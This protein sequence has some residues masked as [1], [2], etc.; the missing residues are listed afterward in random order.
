[1]CVLC[2]KNTGTLPLGTGQ[3]LVAS[4]TYIPAGTS[5]DW[6]K[7]LPFSPQQLAIKQTKLALETYQ[8]DKKGTID[9]T[10]NV[11]TWSYERHRKFSRRPVHPF[12][13]A[14][15]TGGREPMEGE[16]GGLGIYGHFAWQDDV[17]ALYREYLSRQGR[18]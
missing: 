14:Q 2:L 12:C 7:G 4:G 3:T 9:D 16:Y 15:G 6:P 1:M 8:V 17:I 13:R 5:A 10:E 18:L 11:H